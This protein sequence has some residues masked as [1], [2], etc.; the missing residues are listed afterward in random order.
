MAIFAMQVRETGLCWCCWFCRG[1]CVESSCQ[2]APLSTVFFFTS[3]PP[4]LLLFFCDL[5][6]PFPESKKIFF[7]FF[8]EVTWLILHTTST[9][10]ASLSGSFRTAAFEIHTSKHDMGANSAA[11]LPLGLGSRIWLTFLVWACFFPKAALR[12]LW[13]SDQR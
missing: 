12:I 5:T 13:I 6:V 7:P 1:Y 3:L 4:S 10:S 11:F 2:S 9:V 8:P